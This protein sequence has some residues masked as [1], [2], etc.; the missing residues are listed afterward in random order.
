MKMVNVNKTPE[1]E[2]KKYFQKLHEEVLAAF[3]AFSV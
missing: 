3:A 2:A 1:E